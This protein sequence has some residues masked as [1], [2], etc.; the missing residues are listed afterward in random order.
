MRIERTLQIFVYFNTKTNPE[1]E[2]LVLGREKNETYTKSKISNRPTLVHNK[3]AMTW[4][5]SCNI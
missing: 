4:N 5:Q 2:T 3:S 1:T